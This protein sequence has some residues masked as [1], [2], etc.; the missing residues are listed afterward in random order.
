M[1]DA[2][3][4]ANNWATQKREAVEKAKQMRE[5][6][7]Y[8]LAMAGEMS[9]A[10]GM[11]GNNHMGRITSSEHQY[12]EFQK[13]MQNDYMGYRKPATMKYGMSLLDQAPSEEDLMQARSS[14]RLLK[15]KM[16]DSN[17]FSN[18]PAQGFG[19]K[20]RGYFEEETH[21]YMQHAPGE[22]RLGQDNN[23]NDVYQ[24]GN[25]NYRKVFKPNL[26]NDDYQR[27]NNNI[28]SQLNQIDQ[29]LARKGKV[30][31]HANT[32]GP[33]D[34]YQPSMYGGGSQQTR[35]R[36]V[37]MQNDN[38]NYGYKN[39]AYNQPPQN[40]DYSDFSSKNI[41]SRIPKNTLNSTNEYAA[42]KSKLLRNHNDPVSPMYND[43]SNSKGWNDNSPTYD[44]KQPAKLPNSV[45]KNNMA[46]GNKNWQNQKNS[47]FDNE[48]EDTSAFSKP[49]FKKNTQPP[50]SQKPPAASHNDDD[51]RPLQG[52]GNDPSMYQADA[53]PLRE[54][55]M[56]CGR[57]FSEEVLNKHA[58]VCK[59]VFQ[60]KRKKFDSSQQRAT[61]DQAELEHESRY[62]NPYPSKNKG[63]APM[64]KPG[65]GGKGGKAKWKAE[66]EAFRANL[67]AARGA[68][69]SKDEQQ[70]LAQASEAGLTP[71]PH[72]GRKFND[73]AA[74]RHIS[75]CATK[76]KVDNIKKG[77]IKGRR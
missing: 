4:R 51:N 22:R 58:K 59:K 45:G 72:C 12:R 2:S 13:P 42:P 56:G 23:F 15:S 48:P 52:N 37:G 30:L 5:E 17:G 68:P 65:A 77:P 16:K 18:Q 28:N 75:F 20:Q 43:N 69:L 46:G 39:N 32:S 47:H 40:E 63:K 26:G 67:R 49:N 50:K 31:Q 60:S 71:C 36:V 41:P 73:N 7:K 54:C 57:S 25:Q 74:Q 14:L 34:S 55:P 21:E 64:G 70:S 19:A 1:L 9:M 44:Y 10:N 11:G 3:N 76:S 24:N 33:N 8:N 53:G 66:S 29:S 38:K 62:N 61:D 27:Q 6:R 35:P